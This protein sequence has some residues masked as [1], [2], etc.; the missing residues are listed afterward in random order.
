MTV[1]KVLNLTVN[2]EIYCNFYAKTES[3]KYVDAFDTPV[4]ELH[5]KGQSVEKMHK[6]GQF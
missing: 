5:E 2:C 4:L 6:A 1:A 3:A